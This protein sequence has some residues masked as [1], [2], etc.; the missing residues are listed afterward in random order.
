MSI[1]RRAGRYMGI[2]ELAAK[3][4]CS[5]MS[6]VLLLA[7]TGCGGDDGRSSNA[8]YAGSPV[9]LVSDQ[10]GSAEIMT[11]LV[12]EDGGFRFIVNDENGQAIEGV[13]LDYA[14]KDGKCL[15]SITDPAGR[16]LPL[17]I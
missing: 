16:Y 17:R 2:G 9:A 7:T 4:L 13:L 10:D 14:E 6:A 3:L 12:A 11:P 15:I 5:L 8:R 1:A